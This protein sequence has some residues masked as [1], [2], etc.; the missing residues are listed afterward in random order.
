LNNQPIT[1]HIVLCQP[2]RLH[3]LYTGSTI[4]IGT[5]RCH[6]SSLQNEKLMIHSQLA[7]S[8]WGQRTRKILFFLFR[9][10]GC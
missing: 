8:F 6:C 5:R 9:T 3:S 10:R 4:I 2:I 7:P 1:S